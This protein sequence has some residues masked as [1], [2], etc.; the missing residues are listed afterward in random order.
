[1]ACGIKSNSIGYLVA[2][3]DA[4]IWRGPMASKALGRILHETRWERGGLPGGGHA[5]GTSD[6]QLTLAQRC[7]AT[8]A[9][10]VDA[11]GCGAADA[12]R[13]IA[14]LTRSMCL[15]LAF[16]EHELP[17]LQCLRASRAVVRYRRWPKM[18][19]RYHVALLG[20]L[21]LHIDIRQHMDDGCPPCSVR[22]M[23]SC[24]NLPETGSPGRGRALFQRKTDCDPLCHGGAGRIIGVRPRGRIWGGHGPPFHIMDRF[25]QSPVLFSLGI[26]NV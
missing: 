12:R 6:I 20:Q 22:R 3:Q 2:E 24:L 18:A 8:A 1:M 14:M 15:C 4:T 7:P 21:P 13:G 16:V 10:I 23:A 25:K 9:V 26:F 19:E 11:P 5:P 17:R